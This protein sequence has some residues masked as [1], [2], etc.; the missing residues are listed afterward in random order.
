[1]AE[2]LVHRALPWTAVVGM[3]TQTAVVAAKVESIIATYSHRPQ[4]AVVP[5]WYFWT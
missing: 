3:V 1:M 2:F 4:V 5:E